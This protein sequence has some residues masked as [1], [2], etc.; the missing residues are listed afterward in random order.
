MSE[1][2]ELLPRGV[3][4]FIDRYN[5]YLTQARILALTAPDNL[6]K[7]PKIDEIF[8]PSMSLEELR[9]VTGFGIE[10]LSLSEAKLRRMAEG[11]HE[12][13]SFLNWMIGVD[14]ETVLTQ[15]TEQEVTTTIPLNAV[16]EPVGSELKLITELLSPDDPERV[17]G[18]IRMFLA[19]E[20]AKE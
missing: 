14:A 6:K 13:L 19:V 16:D 5:S 1:S 9:T 11:L 15:T 4:A 8:L 2:N 18:A 17:V 12:D 10:V 20:P 3:E 7:P